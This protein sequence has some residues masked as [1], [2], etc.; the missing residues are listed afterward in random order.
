[1]RIL[2]PL[3]LALLAPALMPAPATAQVSA[4]PTSTA[5]PVFVGH[6]LDNPERGVIANRAGI[7]KALALA[8]GLVVADVGAGTGAFMAPIARAVAPTGRYIG[9]D[10][11]RDYVETMRSRAKRAGL[12]NVRVVHSKPGST[13]LAPASVDVIVVIDAYH[14]F[15]P[16]GPMNASMF[17]ALKPG[18]RLV[19]VDFDRTDRSPK[20]VKSHVRA[21]RETFTREIRAAGFRVERDLAV[22]GLEGHFITQFR[23]D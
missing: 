18:G 20:W 15:T 12:A 23:R 5:E 8:P 10:I 14:H 9:V 4:A 11:D 19:I 3:L 1:M 17:Q 16:P 2:L 13:T 21:D 22:P 6:P 7:V